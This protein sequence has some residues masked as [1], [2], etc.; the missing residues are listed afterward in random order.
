MERSPL[1]TQLFLVKLKAFDVERKAILIDN[2]KD[3]PNNLDTISINI[4]DF[5]GEVYVLKTLVHP[6]LNL[7]EVLRN[8]E[9]HMGHCGGM[10]LCASCH[11]YIEKDNI[12]LHDISPEEEDML[13]QLFTFDSSKSRLIC[14]I[15]LQKS[16]D[17]ITLR[18]VRD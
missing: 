12:K 7:M 1:N 18:I 6:D 5:D 13:D 14:Q 16:L 8:A 4:I 2:S 15:Q 17:G 3:N 9:F 10:A 11:C